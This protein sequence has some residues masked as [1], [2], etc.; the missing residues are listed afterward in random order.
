MRKADFKKHHIDDFTPEE[1]ELTGATLEGIQLRLMVSLQTFRTIMDRRVGLLVNGMTSGGHKAKEH[2]LGLA[3]D[4]FLYP[5]E[6]PMDI[7]L[8]FK[9]ALTAG[10]KG[11]GIYW[12]GIQYSFHLDLRPEYGFWSGHKVAK[13]MVKTWRYVSLLKDLSYIV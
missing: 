8:I 7:D 2:F 1:V 13:N 5:D 6:G 4:G 11:I 10:C 9:A 3:V 12:N